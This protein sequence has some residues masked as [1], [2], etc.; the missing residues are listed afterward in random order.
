MAG[1]KKSSQEKNKIEETWND[2]KNFWGIIKELL[3][4]KK[5]RE[6][7]AC[8]YTGEERKEIMEIP[9]KFLGIWQENIYQKAKRSDFSYWHGEGGL[10]EKMLEEKK[11]IYEL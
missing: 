1:E 5:E 2:G 7:E 11:R 3:G 9:D 8:V 4:K 6:E 10:M